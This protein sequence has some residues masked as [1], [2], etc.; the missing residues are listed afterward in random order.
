MSHRFIRGLVVGLIA[1]AAALA[2][3]RT[4]LLQPLEWKSWDARLRLLAR[5]ERADR[6]IVLFLIDQYSLDF[7]EEQNVS[8]PWPRQMY[9]AVIRYFRAGRAKAV[10]LDLILSEPSAYGEEDDR[11]LARAMSEAGNVFL[12]IFLSKD[13]EPETGLRRARA[14]QAYTLLHRFKEMRPFPAQAADPAASASLCLDVLF[15]SAREVG[16]VRFDPDSDGVFRRL[17]LLFRYRDLIVPGL[18]LAVAEFA[19]SQPLDLRRVPL[20]RTGRLVINYHGPTGTYRAYPLAA[21]INSWA[22]ME[23]GRKPQIDPAEFR[24]KIVLV[25]CS[26]PG[27]YDLRPT[28]LSAVSPGTEI[29][30][31]VIDNL[32]HRDFIRVTPPILSILLILLFSLLTGAAVS[33]L[34]KTGHIVIFLVLGLSLPGLAS[35][36]AYWQGLWL[37]FVAP[38]LAV[39]VSFIGAALLN[40]RTEGRQRRFIKNVFRYYL[41]PHVI[42]GILANPSLLRLGGEKR[43]ISSFFSDVQGFTSISENLTPEELVALL[44]A[45]LSEM[46]DII[47]DTGGTL[48][49]YEGDAIIAFWNAPLEQPD[50]AQRACRAALRCQARLGELRAVFKAKYGREVRM[51]I[52]L[53]SGEAVVGNMGSKNRFDYTAMGDTINLAARLEGACKQY[54]IGLLAGEETVSRAGE[55]VVCREVDVI[56]V[57]GKKKSVKVFELIGEAGQ[58]S[59]EPLSLLRDFGAALDSY[60]R[61]EWQKALKGFLAL[62]DDPVAAVYT[63]RC[64]E[65]LISPPPGDWDGVFELKSK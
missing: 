16:N 40:Y 62:K 20:D 45:Y 19:A 26:A 22:M 39:L 17:P 18:P 31:T 57:V 41:S 63:G 36:V 13:K 38:E 21:V 1:F 23:E 30:A 2:V 9:S 3:S 27:L 35:L 42:D 46:T 50:H 34:R 54:G 44:N 12:P 15:E 32:L 25:G 49:K 7:Y 10:F 14:A 28:P 65:L 33:L 59:P 29:Q 53:N 56:R 4:R 64:R 52:G 5:P 43:T 55:A 61:R 8:W 37:E 11:D 58:V 48:D 24:N 60:R 51:R 6:D 47:L